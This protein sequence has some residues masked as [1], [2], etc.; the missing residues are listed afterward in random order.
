MSHRYQSMDE[1]ISQLT[2]IIKV[3]NQDEPFYLKKIFK[4][5]EN[6][7]VKFDMEEIKSRLGQVKCESEWE[8]MNSMDEKMKKAIIQMFQLKSEIVQKY[9]ADYDALFE[10][11]K[12]KLV[13]EITNEKEQAYIC[14]LI[15]NAKSIYLNKFDDLLDFEKFNTV[16]VDVQDEKPQKIRLLNLNKNRNRKFDSRGNFWNKICAEIENVVDPLEEILYAIPL[17]CELKLLN[18]IKMV[19][20]ENEYIIRKE[21]LLVIHTLFENIKGYLKKSFTSEQSLYQKALYFLYSENKELYQ[22]GIRLLFIAFDEKPSKEI[23]DEINKHLPIYNGTPLEY[24]DEKIFFLREEVIYH[25]Y[26]NCFGVRYI[27]GTEKI[28]Y[29]FDGGCTYKILKKQKKLYVLIESICD[30]TV[31]LYVLNSEND[32]MQL[33][34]SEEKSVWF[35]ELVLEQLDENTLQWGEK[36]KWKSLEDEEKQLY[37]IAI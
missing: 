15:S 10:T 1:L 25:T 29:E 27:N 26:H 8:Y 11:L 5:C 28:L 18:Q 35:G 20:E 37:T 4:D 24:I 16:I 14:E 32:K 17:Q 22:E 31:S 13:E 36:T 3:T 6:F 7:E 2:Q 23:S 19:L 30:E 33:L 34:E 21:Y 9:V 12:D